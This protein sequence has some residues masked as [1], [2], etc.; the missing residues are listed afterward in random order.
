LNDQAGT[1]SAPAFLLDMER[2]FERYVTRGVAEAFA[3]SEEY[4][5]A[6]Q[7]SYQ[8]HKPVSR[9]PD[10]LMRPDVTVERN[11]RPCLVV[12]AKWKRTR[13]VRIPTED[14]YQMLAYATGLGVGRAVLVYPG[15]RERSWEYVLTQT[16]VRVEVRTLR[17]TDT[18]VACR[19]SLRRLGRQLGK[20][21]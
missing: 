10:L 4:A 15:K 9:G 19:R 5:V 7:K 16:P 21:A 3:L 14:V 18:A 8:F 6:A 2:V 11:G 17:V 20:R 1:V 13:G 12:D